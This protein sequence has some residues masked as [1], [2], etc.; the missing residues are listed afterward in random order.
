MC[1]LIFFPSNL[2]LR[3][4]KEEAAV[5]ELSTLWYSFMPRWYWDPLSCSTFLHA[6]DPPFQNKPLFHCLP[7]NT[8]LQWSH[9]TELCSAGLKECLQLKS[10]EWSPASGWG[11]AMQERGWD[12]L[13]HTGLDGFF[14]VC[15]RISIIDNL[16]LAIPVIL[17]LRTFGIVKL[18][19]CVITSLKGISIVK[20]LILW[21][22]S[23]KKVKKKCVLNKVLGEIRNDLGV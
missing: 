4:K 20:L 18:S 17:V 14:G 6:R 10:T 9:I 1:M 7:G 22:I 13:G 11:L 15:Y 2:I 5:P 3:E 8:D 21:F 19:W 16:I 23:K 12:W